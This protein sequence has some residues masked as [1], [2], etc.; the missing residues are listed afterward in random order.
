MIQATADEGLNG[1]ASIL[2]YIR[3]KQISLWIENGQIH[4]KA[5]KGSLD[6][7]EL[8]ELRRSKAHL[9]SLLAQ[10]S[11]RR[12][13][14]CRIEMSHAP[15][16]FSQ[17]AHWNVYHLARRPS[18]RQI[19]AA[20]KLHGAVRRAVLEKSISLV[21][22][23]HD[24]LRTRIVLVEGT[25][26][27]EI[28][29]STS[30]TLGIAELTDDESRSQDAISD[31]I[32]RFILEPLD[33]LKEPLLAARLLRIDE[34]EGVLLIAMEHMISDA[35][36]LDIVIRD[37]LSE[38][39]RHL[40]GDANPVPEIAVQFPDYAARQRYALGE[41]LGLHGQYWRDRLSG[42]HRL[43][44]P[45]EQRRKD[46]RGWGTTPIRIDR[47]LKSRLV[48]W[49]RFQKTTP[50]MAVFTA[51]AALCLRWCDASRTIIQYQTHGRYDKATENSVGFFAS[52]LYVR[53][54]LN[55]D[56]SFLNFLAR[57]TEEYCEASLHADCSFF[58]SQRPRPEFAKSFWFNWVPSGRS[59]E[60]PSL[61]GTE[62]EIECSCL[63]FEHPMLEVTQRDNDPLMLLY[64][65]EEEITGGIHFP[66]DRFSEDL[67]S[68][69][70]QKF[71]EFLE[72]MLHNPKTR[73]SR[74][75]QV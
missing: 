42:F 72:R 74:L 44:I 60:L 14:S 8:N 11:L 67:M 26:I 59:Y 65:V 23:R 36:S 5:P 47:H 1:V 21:I 49:S 48:H 62:N 12:A 46:R 19:A 31:E 34:H 58:E 41:W 35:C 57:M 22:Q 54:I 17:L 16:S 2:A 75:L 37:I 13:S 15:L 66:R 73:I 50:V 43:D 30:F 69:F 18:V 6:P 71:L 55:T 7:G 63:D 53:A 38:Y 24:A 33:V 52:V 10:R 4:Y 70:A 20:I 3:S 45:G 64:E 25:P 29:E 68:T 56:D 51:Y 32:R 61:R 9:L 28:A 39:A 27:Q 40:G